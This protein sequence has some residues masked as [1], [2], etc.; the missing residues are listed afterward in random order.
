MNKLFPETSPT[1]LCGSGLGQTLCQS[2]YT[3][4][5]NIVFPLCMSSNRSTALTIQCPS[6]F[7]AY[8]AC[9]RHS[10]NRLCREH[11][12]VSMN[13]CEDNIVQSQWPIWFADI[14]VAGQQAPTMNRIMVVHVQVHFVNYHDA[15]LWCRPADFALCMALHGTKASQ[16]TPGWHI[17]HIDFT[18]ICVACWDCMYA[19]II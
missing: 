10:R 17:S 9:Q 15:C 7:S 11:D 16:P 19:E 5:G 4:A 3:Q 6:P 12:F 13:I 18:T 14:F 8:W 2:C 1:F